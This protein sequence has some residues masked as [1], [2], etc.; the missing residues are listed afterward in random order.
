M[1]KE[2]D[3]KQQD[4]KLL[5]LVPNHLSSL[6]SFDGNFFEETY[7]F[8]LKAYQ[9]L[10]YLPEFNEAGYREQWSEKLSELECLT[11]AFKEYSPEEIQS[12]IAGTIMT[13]QVHIA[14]YGKEVTHG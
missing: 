12:A 9:N 2:N 13:L 10:S 8:F 7:N 4:L 11:L 5:A 3:Q 1:Y 6:Q 14:N